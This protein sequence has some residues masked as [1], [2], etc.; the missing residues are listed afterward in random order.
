MYTNHRAFFSEFLDT[1]VM[2]PAAILKNGR[3]GPQKGQ[4]LAIISLN[5]NIFS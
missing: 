1:I 5:V 4:F 2:S 3:H